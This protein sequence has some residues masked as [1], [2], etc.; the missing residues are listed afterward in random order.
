MR[1]S[2]NQYNAMMNTAF[3]NDTA[4]MDQLNLELATG[5]QYT[6]PS[7]NPIASIQLDRL[8]RSE[9]DITQYQTNISTLQ[10]A[11]SL[12][13]SY[14]NSISNDVLSLHD[15]LVQAA[16]GSNTSADEQSI[17][18][19][20]QPLMQSILYTANSQD[21]EG[22]YVFSGTKTSTPAITYNAAAPVGS[23]Y[24]FTGNTNQ[25]LVA[26]AQGVTQPGN[27]SLPEVATLLNQLDSAQS[28]LSAPGV[29]VNTPAVSTLVATTLTA[30]QTGLGAISSTIATIGGQQ[31]NLQTMNTNFSDILLTDQQETLSLGQVNYAQTY[32]ELTSY[33]TALQAAE[34]AY[35]Q[36]SQLSLWSVA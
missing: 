1:I 34:K 25:Q 36:V 28:T 6:V 12:S 30:V 5:E 11:L 21:A 9:T 10:S 26:V 14:L 35:S 22:N 32:T 13:E 20:M 19:S 31:D 2:T 7:Q 27:V 8:Q 4:Q 17:A 16:N 29:D 23:R 3:Q 24:T 18:S 15:L 33:T